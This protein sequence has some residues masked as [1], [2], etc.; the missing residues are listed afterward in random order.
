MCGIVCIILQIPEGTLF[1]F[2]KISQI[3]NI[4]YDFVEPSMGFGFNFFGYEIINFKYLKYMHIR[5]EY[6]MN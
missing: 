3:C 5:V 2:K 6:L 4:S 1:F